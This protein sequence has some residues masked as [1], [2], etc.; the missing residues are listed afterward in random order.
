MNR[1]RT[2]WIVVAIVLLAV[3]FYL[4][5]SAHTPPGQQPLVLLTESNIGEFQNIFDGAATSTRIVLLVS[6]T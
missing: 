2:L 5:G 3:A 6:P 4:W 1:Q